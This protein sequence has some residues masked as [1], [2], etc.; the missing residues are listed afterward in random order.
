MNSAG[1]GLDFP[2]TEDGDMSLT[3][4]D[5]I[6][7]G[8]TAPG[9]QWGHRAGHGRQPHG[10]RHEGRHRDRR[11]VPCGAEPDG[12]GLAVYTCCIPSTL[13]NTHI[14]ARGGPGIYASID[15]TPTVE[16]SLVEGQDAIQTQAPDSAHRAPQPHHGH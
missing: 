2:P 9:V 12:H 16:D 15:S 5:V 14:I 13:T 1:T 4:I 6:G 10:D 3:L 8:G 7:V 11:G